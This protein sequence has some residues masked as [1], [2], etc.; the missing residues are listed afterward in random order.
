MFNSLKSF[1][2]LSIFIFVKINANETNEDTIRNKYDI[3]NT[4]C[5]V[6]ISGSSPLNYTTTKFSDNDNLF[7]LTLVLAGNAYKYNISCSVNDKNYNVGDKHYIIDLLLY[8][9]IRQLK[10]MRYS[11]S[12]TN[13]NE[14][15]QQS[16]NE[17]A[18]T[19]T[20]SGVIFNELTKQVS[21]GWTG[22]TRMLCIVKKYNY[23]LNKFTRCEQSMYLNVKEKPQPQLIAS[24]PSLQKLMTKQQIIK[25]SSTIIQMPTWPTTTTVLT[26]NVDNYS[27]N[28]AAEV[29]PKLVKYL[30]AEASIRKES[31]ISSPSIIT[32]IIFLTFFILIVAIIIFAKNFRKSSRSACQK[33]NS[34][35]NGLFS[36]KNFSPI[37]LD[38]STPLSDRSNSYNNQNVSL[39]AEDEKQK[40]ENS[41]DTLNHSIS[42]RCSRFIDEKDKSR[43]TRADEDSVI[44]F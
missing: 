3:D 13:Q 2:S 40:L 34:K 39:N 43:N 12:T 18:D 37:S 20:E 36:K 29:E 21:F 1:I 11:F 31:N 41:N 6:R 44:L 30:Q 8:G 15:Q 25:K 5:Q 26:A 7:N 19:T 33:F 27:H 38:R 9:P 10:A 32:L 24:M 16:T 4:F 14:S 22:Q 17:E 28:T 42:S 23:L 35:S